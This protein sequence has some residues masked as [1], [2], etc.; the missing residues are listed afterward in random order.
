MGN[1]LLK[2]VSRLK[3]Q[4]RTCRGNPEKCLTGTPDESSPR[5]HISQDGTSLVHVP[6]I[7]D[8]FCSADTEI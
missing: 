4:S 3:R 2:S 7:L 1:L 6:D 5:H 8:Q